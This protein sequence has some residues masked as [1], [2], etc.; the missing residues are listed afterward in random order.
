MLFLAYFVA[1]SGV[2]SV[3]TCYVILAYFVFG[4]SVF[5]VITCLFREGFL[6]YFVF[7]FGV[8]AGT[9]MKLTD[10]EIGND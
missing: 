8:L 9:R 1:G 2:F 4:S 10:V 6:T 3:I 7:G 5:S